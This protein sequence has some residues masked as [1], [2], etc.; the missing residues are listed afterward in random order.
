MPTAVKPERHLLLTEPSLQ[1]IRSDWQLNCVQAEFAAVQ[2]HWI[3]RAGCAGAQ[4][5]TERGRSARSAAPPPLSRSDSSTLP[6]D[7]PLR[8]AAAVASRRAAAALRLG[9]DRGAVDYRP[10]PHPGRSGTRGHRSGL[11]QIK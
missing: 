9:C 4:P 6:S 11:N 2:S 3:H 10:R 8:A 5:I 7:L 1:P